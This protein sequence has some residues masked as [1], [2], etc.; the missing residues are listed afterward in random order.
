MTRGAHVP[1]FALAA[2]LAL[3]GSS[4]S[5]QQA[6]THYT[7]PSEPPSFDIL[8]RAEPIVVLARVGDIVGTSKK[9]FETIPGEIDHAPAFT[10]EYHRYRLRTVRLLKGSLPESFD[11][12]VISGTRNHVLLDRARG[13]EMLLVLAP[14]SGLDPQGRPRD[15]F[16]ITHGA[17]YLVRDG[18]FQAAGE[19]GPETWL[20]ER[21]TDVIGRFERERDQQRADSPE[22][23][24]AAVAV[25]SGEDRPDRAEPEPPEA[26]KL[27]KGE[28]L[29]AD[30]LAKASPKAIESAGGDPKLDRTPPIHIG[31]QAPE[32]RS[33][34]QLDRPLEFRPR[35]VLRGDVGSH[36]CLSGSYSYPYEAAGITG[37]EVWLCCIPVDEILRESFQC[38]GGTLPRPF[39]SP[40]YI[41]IRYCSLLHPTASEPTY[42][43]VCIPAPL[44]APGLDTRR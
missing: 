4:I 32:R 14:D 22:P 28:A 35:R 23:R 12:R 15:T 5:N 30:L 20:V 3:L 21:A 31:P 29:P 33:Q 11:V 26:P 40:E 10:E 44:Q 25:F 6:L 7:F 42:I 36:A 27:R 34:I 13:Q 2:S 39:G 19:R 37:R 18:R 17:A 24:D 43:P 16:L 8:L 41:K 9:T 1:S 38:A